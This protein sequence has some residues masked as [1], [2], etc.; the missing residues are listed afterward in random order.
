MTKPGI[1]DARLVDKR[2]LCLGGEDLPLLLVHADVGV[3]PHGH[4]RHYHVQFA[5]GSSEV[6]DLW[7]EALLGDP[8]SDQEVSQLILGLPGRPHGRH[9]EALA[10][11]EVDFCILAGLPGLFPR[12]EGIQRGNVVGVPARGT[13]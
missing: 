4:Q 12:L 13:R 5:V 3:G 9:V 10:V 2:G 11:A 1:V 6:E 8:A 7:G